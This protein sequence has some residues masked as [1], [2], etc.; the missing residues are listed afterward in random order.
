MEKLIEFLK[1]NN[2]NFKEH[3]P[4]KPYTTWKV[5]GKARLL[6]DLKT[7]KEASLIIKCVNDNNIDHYYLGSGSNVLVSDDG[8]DGVVIKNSITGIEIIG[9][10]NNKSEDTKLNDVRLIQADP[11]KYYNFTE[12]DYDESDKEKIK[13]MVES[14]T[15]LS[16]TINHLIGKGITGLQWFSGIPGT[17]GGA[18]YNNIHGGSHF[19]SEYV[20]QVDLI[21]KD[22][23]I[24]SLNKNEMGFGYDNS[25]L[26]NKG[27]FILTIHFDLYKGDKERALSTAM[28]WA[29]AKKEKQP[30]NSA[31]CCFKNITKEELEK[32]G[33]ISNS[34]GYIIEH[35]LKLKGHRVGDAQISNKH[36]AFIENLGEAKAL[37][38]I[39]LMELIYTKSME[40]FNI[41]PKSEIFFLGFPPNR[42][43]KFL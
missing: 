3:E 40:K 2:I 19:F 8:Y 34:W 25:K 38:I 35:K 17:V 1:E 14:G 11:D 5:G 23:N 32:E 9:E 12:L 24:V 15:L 36:A 41:A 30:Y 22:G 28:K 20:T 6:I 31:G 26:Q 4:L 29:R 42:V 27:M 13:V 21:D 39:T 18:V 33:F 7:K 37:D 16:Y 10:S 43:K